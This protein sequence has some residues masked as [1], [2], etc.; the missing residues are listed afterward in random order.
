MKHTSMTIPNTV[1]FIRLT[2][3]QPGRVITDFLINLDM[4]AY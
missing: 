3:N 4:V 1:D 2:T